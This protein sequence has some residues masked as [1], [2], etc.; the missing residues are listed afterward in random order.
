MKSKALKNIIPDWYGDDEKG[1]FK[2]IA[3]FIEK[4]VF[5]PVERFFQIYK[6]RILRSYDYAKFGWDNHDWDMAYVYDVFLFKLKRLYKG[7]ENGHAIHEDEDMVA[8]KELTKIVYRLRRENHERK[9]LRKHDKKWGKLEHRTEPCL[10][11]EGRRKGMGQWIIWRKNC[12][13][14]AAQELK[15]REKND[16]LACFE[17]GE[18]DRIRDINKMAEILIKHSKAF[19]D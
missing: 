3:Y 10:D 16:F 5:W 7:L 13:E 18:R 6:E 1:F 8:L 14:N 12:P 19:W 17:D 9:Y 4:Y 2:K 11:E 15:D